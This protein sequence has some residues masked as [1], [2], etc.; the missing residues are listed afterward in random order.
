MSMSTC[1]SYHQVNPE[2]RKKK[3][4]LIYLKVVFIIFYFLVS[5]EERLKLHKL[6]TLMKR[7][8]TKKRK[9]R[10]KRV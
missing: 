5:N 1:L 2:I 6:V 9:T 8:E 3:I 10:T 7:N 4:K